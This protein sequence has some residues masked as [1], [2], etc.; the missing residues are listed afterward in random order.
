MGLKGDEDNRQELGHG[1]L[2]TLLGLSYQGQLS[3]TEIQSFFLN[4]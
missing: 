2:D 1:F 4:H 3:I